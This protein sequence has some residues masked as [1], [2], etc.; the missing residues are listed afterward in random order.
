MAWQQ[1]GAEMLIKA[2]CSMAG[3]DMA[4]MRPRVMRTMNSIKLI[5]EQ[6]ASIEATCKNNAASLARIEQRME[7]DEHEPR[8]KQI[9]P[10]SHTLVNGTD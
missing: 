5:H 6:I 7:N 10:A 4:E 2:I 9:E 1:Q 3:I 8:R